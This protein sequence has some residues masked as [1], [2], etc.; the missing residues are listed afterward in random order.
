MS[1]SS[2]TQDT[3]SDSWPPVK[4]IKLQ[5]RNHG[6][7]NNKRKVEGKTKAFALKVNCSLDLMT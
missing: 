5:L 3:R 6:K 4:A 7:Q 2:L 1:V